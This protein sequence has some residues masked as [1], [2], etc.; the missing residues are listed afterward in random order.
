MAKF[1][2]L[3]NQ[4]FGRLTVVSRGDNDGT[5]ATWNCVCECGTETNVDGKKLRSGHTKSCGC[6]RAE[7]SAP[8]TGHKN[9]R[10]G[11]AFRTPTYRTWA[12]MIQRCNNPSN[13]DYA[14]YGAKGV[15]VCD[16]W[17][18]FKLFLE[19]MGERPGGLTLDRINPYGNYEPS[20]CRWADWIV[21]AN[22]RRIHWKGEAN[23]FA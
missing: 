7:V 8:K 14:D 5:R 18:D 9:M 13:K 3:T 2:D 23:V 10:H 16:R 1:I 4:T 22:N 21:Q 19:D 17:R 11:Y 20:N 6:Y 12:G 15:T